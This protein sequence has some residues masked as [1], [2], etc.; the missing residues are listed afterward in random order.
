MCTF[1]KPI[2]DQDVFCCIR[3]SP[4]ILLEKLLTDSKTCTEKTETCGTPPHII[5]FFTTPF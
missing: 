5:L 4:I 3:E 1:W 2:R